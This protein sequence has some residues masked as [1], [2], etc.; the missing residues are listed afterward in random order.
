M[1]KIRSL[2]RLDVEWVRVDLYT[3]STETM[4]MDRR[5]TCW[6][7]GGKFELGNGM[8]LCGTARGNKTVHTRC[9]QE[10]QEGDDD[11]VP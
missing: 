11:P 4:P 1:A 9:Y 10:Q 8:T 7:C 3:V 5:R 6:I 2:Q